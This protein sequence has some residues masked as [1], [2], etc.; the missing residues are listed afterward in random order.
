M[1]FQRP[2]SYRENHVIAELKAGDRSGAPERKLVNVINTAV[3]LHNAR[4]SDGSKK[5]AVV[6]GDKKLKV[7]TA[8]ATTIPHNTPPTLIVRTVATHTIS[9]GRGSKHCRDFSISEQH[10]SRGK[11]RKLD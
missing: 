6:V 4:T 1:Q 5:L 2:A 11:R 9:T 3:E 10:G 8:T 7:T